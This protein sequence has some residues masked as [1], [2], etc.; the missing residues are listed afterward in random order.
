MLTLVLPTVFDLI[1]VAD[2]HNASIP[3]SDLLDNSTLLQLR[4]LADTHEFNLAYNASDPIRAIAGST[5]AAQVVQALNSSI[6]STGKTSKL[7]VQF[8]AYGS[9]QS[10]FGLSNLTTLPGENGTNFIGVPD[11]AST[12]TFELFTT[13]AP[14]PYPAVSDL[15]VR[16][17]FH[18]GTTGNSSTPQAF[19]LFGGSAPEMSWNDFVTG[20]NKFAVGTQSQ[21][22]QAC[23]NTTG[24]CSASTTGSGSSSSPSASSSSDKSGGNGISTAVGGV[25][26]AMVTLAVIL[27][28]EALIMLVGGLRLV[29]KNRS[30]GSAATNGSSD[31]S[32]GAKAS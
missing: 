8:G 29:R 7:S 3:S 1:N 15:Q 20:M 2:I 26:G 10:F 5:L 25:I 6:T 9:F 24:V 14:D 13:A 4:T 12:M 32:P 21:W 18:N 31:G 16:F 19:P 23:G 27:G 30:S 22:C 28:I 11:Y 17:Y